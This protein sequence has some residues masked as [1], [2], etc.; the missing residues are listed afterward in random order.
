[1]ESHHHDMEEKKEEK[2]A[3]SADAG[4][5]DHVGAAVGPSRAREAFKKV[6]T[7]SF[8]QGACA[9]VVLLFVAQAAFDV[10]FR[11]KF[12][13]GGS[14]AKGASNASQSSSGNSASVASVADYETAV[15]PPSGV[16]L[17][18]RWG[19]LGKRMVDAGVI[20]SEKFQ[21]IYAQRGGLSDDEKELLLGAG[22]GNL[23]IDAENS[24]FLLNLLWA[25]GLGNKNVILEEG[26]MMQSGDASRFA[27]TG[28]W[29]I[30][31]GSPMDHYSTHAF[32]TL[33]DEQHKLVERVSQNIYR[34]CCGNST[35]F[36]D[37]NH[38]MAML[39]LLE[40]M[41]S[42]GV[43]EEEMYRVALVVNSYW[44]PSTY[45]TIA[46]YKDGQGIAWGDVEPKEVLGAAYSSGSGYK[47]I[48]SQVAPVTQSGGGGCGV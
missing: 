17:P 36:P 6:N 5:H 44:F 47:K 21:A 26:P 22:N 41:A 18:V 45:L 48:L 2:A 20:D 42:Q 46:K 12:S 35:Y 14:G 13:F 1:M 23:K 30:A 37:C 40:L 8:W 11:P 10:N 3:D 27:S 38:G 16:E 33:S 24:G 28:G 34:P 32:V 39:G 4:C 29:S 43:S 7:K 19:D 15:L 9:A 31:K 25:F